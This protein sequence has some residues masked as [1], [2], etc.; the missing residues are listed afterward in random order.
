MASGGSNP[1]LSAKGIKMKQD[2]KDKIK[3]QVFIVIAV[4]GIIVWAAE[5]ARD[6]ADIRKL[7]MIHKEEMEQ[8]NDN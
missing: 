4:L 6:K 2:T 8:I 7:K 1:S 3:A 5:E